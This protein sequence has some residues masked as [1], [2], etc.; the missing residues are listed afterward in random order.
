MFKRR[1]V[2]WQGKPFSTFPTGSDGDHDE[3]L[4][5]IIDNVNVMHISAKPTPL[6]NHSARIEP[7][8]VSGDAATKLSIKPASTEADADQVPANL[9]IPQVSPSSQ[10]WRPFTA[11]MMTMLVLGAIALW[12]WQRFVPQPVSPVPA[13]ADAHAL[14]T[15]AQLPPLWRQEYGFVL[16]T[17]AEPGETET[18]KAQW[19]QYLLGNALPTES[20]S[21]WHQG[22]DGLQ[23]L[24]HRLNTPGERNGRYLT[25]SELKSMV[26]T[27]TQNFS[28]SVP[29]EEQLYQLGQSENAESG[30]AA[31]LAQV[32]M[33]FTQLLNRY[34]LIKNQI[35]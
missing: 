22:M 7:A 4:P 31:Q 23:A 35:E 33:Q 28:R 17:R 20:L 30:R 16:A 3:R 14:T 34:A 5:E 24:T 13:I 9:E 15:L 19:Q 21:G 6:A 8:T 32:D 29:L 12:S 25:G 1:N 26:F 10:T 2:S 27:I 18:L 11:G